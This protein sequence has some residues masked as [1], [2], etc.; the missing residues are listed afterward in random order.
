MYC[1]HCGV[2]VDSNQESMVHHLSLCKSYLQYC[3]NSHQEG[4]LENVSAKDSVNRNNKSD[5][6]SVFLPALRVETIVH[7]RMGVIGIYSRYEIVSM[8]ITSCLCSKL[9]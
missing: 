7:L 2:A 3:E 6:R 4:E 9:L 5:I 8:Y 1:L